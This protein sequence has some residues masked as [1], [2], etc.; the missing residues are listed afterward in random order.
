V[1]SPDLLPLPNIDDSKGEATCYLKNA[2]QQALHT[3]EA[4]VTSIRE[5]TTTHSH[6]YIVLR[7]TPDGSFI[8]SHAKKDNSSHHTDFVI[9]TEE[10]TAYTMLATQYDPIKTCLNT[11]TTRRGHTI[12]QITP[13][14][15]TT[16]ITSIFGHT[17]WQLLTS[18]D[19][20]QRDAN[21]PSLRYNQTKGLTDR[22]IYRIAW[23]TALMAHPDVLT[24]Y[25]EGLQEIEEMQQQ[26]S[27][28]NTPHKP[29]PPSKGNIKCPQWIGRL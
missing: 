4:F 7:A 14:N 21:T 16:H 22:H 13:I 10:P 2:L 5:L 18:P 29:T 26:Q 24:T 28:N 19:I 15:L 17:Y 1:Q 12:Q 25:E 6:V 11:T 23:A 3:T 9:S 27:P 8:L 20:T